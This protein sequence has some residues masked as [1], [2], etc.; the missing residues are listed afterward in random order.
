L[1]IPEKHPQVKVAH[2]PVNARLQGDERR[3]EHESRIE[4]F[5]I[6]HQ[7]DWIFLAGY[8]R[9]LTPEFARE[10]SVINI[11]P[12]LLPKYPGLHAYE[13]AWNAG[14]KVFGITVHHVD[15]GVDTGK[16]IEQVRF[17]RY[18]GERLED[19]I[20]RGKRIEWDL[21]GRVLRTL[22]EKGRL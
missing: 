14:E 2:V 15:E 1:E 4:A 19:L 10:H 17:E 6:Q 13:Q 20:E 9:V 22:N 18:A 12:S 8:M 7:I 3:R 21:Y 16:V 11:H 5:L